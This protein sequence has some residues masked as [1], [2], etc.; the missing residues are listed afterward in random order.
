MP[1]PEE[2]A[3]HELRGFPFLLPL[4][5]FPRR[6][7]WPAFAARLVSSEGRR[8]GEKISAKVSVT[9]PPERTR[10][11]KGGQ[12]KSPHLPPFPP[13]LYPIDFSRNSFV[14][15]LFLS[16]LQGRDEVTGENPFPPCAESGNEAGPPSPFF[17]ELG[18]LPGENSAFSLS[19]FGKEAVVLALFFSFCFPP[20]PH[21]RPIFP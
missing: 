19:S 9:S 10:K 11:K 6:K 2:K 1:F 7:A 14:P 17:H 15:I 5:P 3:A 12:G 21:L 4:S 20:F 16:Y 18:V 8:K 13:P